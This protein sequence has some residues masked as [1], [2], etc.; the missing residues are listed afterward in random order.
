MAIIYKI[1]TPEEW[2]EFQKRGRFEGSPLDKRDGF[3]HLA[4]EHQYPAILEKFFKEVDSVVLIK[5]D[6]DLLDAGNTLK[7]ESNRVGGEKFPHLY[8]ALH[9]KAVISHE[10]LNLTNPNLNSNPQTK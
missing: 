9:A 10:V 8:G 3:I 2:S 5:I 6:H 4:L 1:L 7:I